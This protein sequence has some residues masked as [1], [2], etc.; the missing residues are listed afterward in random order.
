V[1]REEQRRAN[2]GV[3][4]VRSLTRTLL[5][6]F[7]DAVR[8]LPGS[9]EVQ[10]SLVTESLTY[11]DRLQSDAPG[12]KDLTGD[13]IEALIRLGN[14]QSENLTEP[15]AAEKTLRKAAT[16]ART[17]GNSKM[18]A[19]AEGNLGKALLR[20]GSTQDGV[21]LLRS[22]TAALYKM[23]DSDG[24]DAALL[25]EC[26]SF[27]GFLGGTSVKSDPAG[28]EAQFTRQAEL[29][30]RAI[31]RESES[32]SARLDLAAA[33]MNLAGLK[34]TGADAVAVL[35]SGLRVLNAEPIGKGSSTANLRVRAS[36]LVRLALQLGNSK[37]ALQ[38]AQEARRLFVS[39]AALEPLSGQS[40]DDFSS[41]NRI[42]SRLS[43]NSALR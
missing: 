26:A 37:D 9:K 29:D 28:A 32:Q 35:R 31:Q 23:A 36:I 6:E 15:E 24:A 16:L 21:L 7:Y 11:L 25:V 38:S 14:L 41:A 40:Q 17:A 34:R 1:A 19:L 27:H 30:R 13:V 22:A 20:K 18:A 39:V 42:I 8:V 5:F 33:L 3:R 12:D 43:G 10:K 4:D 2:R